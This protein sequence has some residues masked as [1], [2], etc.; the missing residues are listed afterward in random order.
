MSRPPRPCAKCPKRDAHG[1]C[2][3]KGKWVSMYHPSCLYGRRMMNNAV[4]AECNR[5]RFGWKKRKP[6]PEQLDD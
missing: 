6:K 4:S 3:I 2:V 5:K 1:V